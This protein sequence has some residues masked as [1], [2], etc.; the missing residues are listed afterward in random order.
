MSRGSC[1]RHAGNVL[2][3]AYGKDLTS[4]SS[5]RRENVT[6]SSEQTNLL[7]DL[8]NTLADAVERVG[9]S[10]VAVK[11][12]SRVPSSGVYWQQGIIVTADHT[13]ERDDNI[14]VTLPDGNDVQAS[15][16][17]RDSGTDLAV[18][19][20]DGAGLSGA[21]LGDANELRVGHLVL[22]VARP[23]DTG[24][25]ATMGP[26]SVVG[27]PWRTWSGGQID[28]LVR[29]DLT[30]YPGFSGGPLIDTQGRV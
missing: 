1:W 4:P 12:R 24:L 13:V 17:A 5:N 23:G 9:K 7:V 29:P 22:A 10:V 26:V 3:Q 14:T 18:L 21:T 25:S 6:T 16:A 28:R 20:V 27:G 19:K 8:S 2:L 15:L 30:L 11:A